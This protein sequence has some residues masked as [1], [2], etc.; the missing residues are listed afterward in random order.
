MQKSLQIQQVP[1]KNLNL[2]PYNP[3]R[4]EQGAIDQLTE[5]IRKFGLVD[6]I[7]VNSAENRKNIVIGGHFRL[8]VAKSLGYTEVPVIFLNIPDIEKEKELN[9]RL[10]RNIGDWDF[11][12]L[13]NFDTEFLLDIG[14][15]EQDLSAIWDDVLQTEE[16]DFDTEKALEEIKIPQ[17]KL[18]EIYQLGQHKLVCGDSTD[19]AIV[20]KLVGEEKVDLV[21]CDPIYNIDLS[22][23]KGI[24][25]KKNYGGQTNDRKSDD[26]YRGFLKRT[27]QNALSVAKEDLHMF[28]YCDENYIGMVQRLFAELGLTNRRV[29]FWIKNN[30][31]I[32]P[33]I[34]FNKVTEACVYATKGKPYLN[35]DCTKFNEIM[36]KEIDTGN[37]ALDDI[38][39]LLNI[40]LVKRLPTAEYTHPTEKSVTLHE[41]VLRRCTKIGDKVLELFGGSGSTLIACEQMKRTCFIAEIDPIFATLIIQR[42]EKLTGQKARKPN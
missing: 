24:G 1:I 42:Y 10:N 11:D 6:P 27:I 3:R 9:L 16:D 12:L 20:Q 18:G 28:Y 32:T 35:A 21:Y 39:D 31:N 4:W 29:N 41:K 17:V 14:F 37:R 22:Y 5:S 26:E 25:G 15:D 38:L 30:A 40:W 8:S 2:A 19:P 36:N 7:L 23:A 34:A 13:K 33:Q